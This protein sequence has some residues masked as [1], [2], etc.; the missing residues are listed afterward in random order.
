MSLKSEMVLSGS[1]KSKKSQ[2]RFDFLL[3]LAVAG[4]FVIGV[5]AIYSAEFSR[6]TQNGL[7]FWKKQ[8][9]FLIPGLFVFL[10]FYLFN[11][12][13]MAKYY[14]FLYLISISLLIAVMIFGKAPSDTG[15]HKSWF[16][17]GGFGIQPSEFTKLLMIIFYAKALDKFGDR[18][19][20]L[21]YFLLLLIIPMPI[22]GLIALQ[23][24]YGTTLVYFPII[25]L[26]L[27]IAGADPK[28]ILVLIG[29]GFLA[30]FSG[31]ITEASNELISNSE[32]LLWAKKFFNI[33]QNLTNLIILFAVLALVLYIFYTRLKFRILL[34]LDLF[35]VTFA[36]GLLLSVPVRM[37]VEPH[38]VARLFGFI[39]LDYD[40]TNINYNLIQVR[41]AMGSGGWSGQGY[42]QG[43]QTQLD[44]IPKKINDF[45]ASVVGEELGYRMLLLVLILFGVLL[46]CCVYTIYRTRNNVG[47]LI[48][49]GIAAMFLA[50]IFINI[51]M[52][53]GI[54]PVIGIPLPFISA[55]GSSLV[56]FLG[57]IGLVMNVQS[58]KY[59]PFTYGES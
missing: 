26:M 48:V 54:M 12:K 11:Y 23:G 39:N 21:P 59:Q 44:Y 2:L 30:I 15:G 5:V 32:F 55:G 29:I 58:R 45:I 8:F 56:T 22:I 17:I 36:G 43:K 34:Y 10:F 18:I 47:R 24:D 16:N 50:H 28:I 37:L 57:A 27:F 52:C 33:Q 7:P 53:I 1:G 4:L 25:L 42:L 13:K 3:F 14:V 49:S 40:P 6:M 35:L 46:G 38:H 20:K 31:V 51:G 9:L 41:K 19:R